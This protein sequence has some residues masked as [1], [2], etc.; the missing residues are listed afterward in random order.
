M[1]LGHIFD[2]HHKLNQPYLAPGATEIIRQDLAQRMDCKFIFRKMLHQCRLITRAASKIQHLQLFGDQYLAQCNVHSMVQRS[3]SGQW[4]IFAPQPPSFYSHIPTYILTY[5]L[6]VYLMNNIPKSPK[7]LYKRMFRAT[8]E[9]YIYPDHLHLRQTTGK[10]ENPK[11]ESHHTASNMLI[12]APHS[13][14]IL[15]K[16]AHDL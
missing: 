7:V 6:I 1:N 11:L 10:A 13:K 9:S 15:W 16:L 3:S 4:K 12:K 8:D 14:T 2:L 5:I